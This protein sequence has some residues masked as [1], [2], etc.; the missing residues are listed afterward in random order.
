MKPQRVSPKSCTPEPAFAAE[1]LSD[2]F[3]HVFPPRFER[4]TQLSKSRA[5][6][7]FATGIFSFHVRRI[8]PPRLE[9]GTQLSESRAMTDFA[10][11]K[12]IIFIHVPATIRTWTAAFVEPRDI[13]FHHENFEFLFVRRVYSPTV[14]SA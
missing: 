2:S 9:R 7:D 5:I 1:Q 4:G 8:F 10:T 3:S 13:H 6:T 12:T 11:G 14:F